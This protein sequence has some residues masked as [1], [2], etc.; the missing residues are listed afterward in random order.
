M[1][2]LQL[3]SERAKQ[4]TRTLPSPL[5]P[6]DRKPL[7]LD[8]KAIKIKKKSPEK[9]FM[10]RVKELNLDPVLLDEYENISK[11]AELNYFKSTIPD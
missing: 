6:E 1:F 9:R 8:R 11:L 2:S 5:K 7:R 4:A 3:S 10:D